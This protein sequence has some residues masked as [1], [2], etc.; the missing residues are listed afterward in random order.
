MD[1]SVIIPMAGP[2]GEKVTYGYTLHHFEPKQGK[3]VGVWPYEFT[4][5]NLTNLRTK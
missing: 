1:Y 4:L 2:C 5:S 3:I